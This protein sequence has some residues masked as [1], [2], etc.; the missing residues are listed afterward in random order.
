MFL[1]HDQRRR[2][3]TARDEGPCA[4]PLQKSVRQLRRH[5][6]QDQVPLQLHRRELGPGEQQP[7]RGGQRLACTLVEPGFEG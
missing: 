2:A 1:R 6:V 7:G 3:Q 4:R 5:H